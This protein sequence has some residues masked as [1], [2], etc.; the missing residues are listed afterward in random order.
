[1]S[2]LNTRF[3]YQKTQGVLYSHVF[4]VEERPDSV[5]KLMKDCDEVNCTLIHELAGLDYLQ[6]KPT[7]RARAIRLGLFDDCHETL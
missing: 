4:A 1:M 3:A 7:N 6:S 2:Q 5:I